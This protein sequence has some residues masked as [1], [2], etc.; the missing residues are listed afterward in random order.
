MTQESEAWHDFQNVISLLPKESIPLIKELYQSAL[1]YALARGKFQIANH[2]A[3]LDMD[4]SRSRSHDR[5][6][7]ASNAVSRACAR[8]EVS[9][10]WRRIW[11]DAKNGE[12]RRRIDDFACFIA[13]QLAL[14]SR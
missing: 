8:T 13:Y 6:I 7:D 10:E 11:G 14:S 1:D 5:F 4:A 2:D 12:A 9:Q 3:R